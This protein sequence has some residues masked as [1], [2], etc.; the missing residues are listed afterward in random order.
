MET[1]GHYE[2]LGLLSIALGSASNATRVLEA[3][4]DLTSAERA[5]AVV[6]S[7]RSGLSTHKARKLL[8]AL[9]LGR[10]AALPAWLRRGRLVRSHAGGA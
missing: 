2:D 1:T 7:Q 5:G 6:I 10:R 8:A 4:G 9:L 3:F